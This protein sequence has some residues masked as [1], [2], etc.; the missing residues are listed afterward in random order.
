MTERD[1]TTSLTIDTS[2]TSPAV[3]AEQFMAALED[4]M[5]EQATIFV[6]NVVDDATGKAHVVRITPSGKVLSVMSS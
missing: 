6:L 4:L 5:S 3:A 2:G 1:F